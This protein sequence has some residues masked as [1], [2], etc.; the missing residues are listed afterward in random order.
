MATYSTHGT[1]RSTSGSCT[2]TRRGRTRSLLELDDAADAL[3]PL[4]GFEGLVDLGEIDA[5]GDHVLEVEL[6]LAPQPQEHVEVGTNVS[7]AVPAP[8]KLLLEVE[9]L[10]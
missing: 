1:R 5:A 9:E 2:P 4:H 3:A 6:A 10:E 7:R 8:Q